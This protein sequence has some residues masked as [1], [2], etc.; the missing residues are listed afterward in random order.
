M[1]KILVYVESQNAVKSPKHKARTAT[2]S[3]TSQL[4]P[5]RK[6]SL[7]DETVY[8]QMGPA[9][10]FMY[11]K[12]WT[13]RLTEPLKSTRDVV[14]GQVYTRFHWMTGKLE[15]AQK[16]ESDRGSSTALQ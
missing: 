11:L 2:L 5:R 12:M 8:I 16:N 10:D 15:V 14:L 13:Y 1:R 7:V 4:Y 6:G 9:D 3:E